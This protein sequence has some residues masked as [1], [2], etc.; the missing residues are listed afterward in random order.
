VIWHHAGPAWS[1]LPGS[2][3]GFLG[4]DMFFVISGFLIVTLL[5][6]ERGRNGDV[7]LR[8]FYVRRTLR[9]F[10]PYYA[11]LGAL[12]LHAALG[13]AS[14][15]RAR[16]VFAEL[17]YYLT[18]TSNWVF[19][20][21]LPLT[22]SL[23][24]EEQFYLAWPWVEKYARRWT[25]ALLALVL[26]VSQWMN[27]ARGSAPFVALFGPDHEQLAILQVTFTPICLGVLLAHALDSRSGFERLARLLAARAA[28]VVLAL[29][30]LAV[31][32]LPNDDI[33]GWHRL[34]LHVLMTALV[35]ACVVREDHALQPLMR[36]PALRRIGVV[37]YGMYL[38]HLFAQHAV[39]AALGRLGLHSK[40]LGFAACLLLAWAIAE[41][42]FRLLETPFLRMKERFS[43]RPA[44]ARPAFE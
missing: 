10:P 30:T 37:S 43:T 8:D 24:T 9:I 36:W 11:L 19:M 27:F 22:W 5:L 40:L 28:P 14:P 31:A 38:Y 23:A 39:E 29:A 18:Y 17:P 42:S 44:T 2:Q 35:G 4:V 33:S 7:S 34:S 41:L 16:L 15:E 20:V 1:A 26:V 21:V 25:F 6:R 32:N 3:R 12:A 13:L